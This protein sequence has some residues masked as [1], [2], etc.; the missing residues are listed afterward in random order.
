MSTPMKVSNCYKVPLKQW[1]KWSQ[2]AQDLFNAVYS[3]MY[4]N[5]S[6]FQ[7]P[8]ALEIET[9]HWKTTAWNAAW[10]AANAVDDTI[11]RSNSRT[12]TG[13]SAA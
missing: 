10:T 7:H 8:K 4:D 12:L 13:K 1:A 6:L 5:Q 9:A 11:L 2:R 3:D